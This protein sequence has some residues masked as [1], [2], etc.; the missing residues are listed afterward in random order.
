MK[1]GELDW[2]GYG[3]ILLVGISFCAL[4]GFWA[5]V[6]MVGCLMFYVGVKSGDAG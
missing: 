6:G 5:A 2:L 3:G 4:W 1:V